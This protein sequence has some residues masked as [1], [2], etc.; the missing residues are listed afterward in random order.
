MASEPLS[1]TAEF[2]DRFAGLAL[3]CVDREYPN[4]I[5][6]LVQSDAESSPRQLSAPTYLY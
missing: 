4:H 6:H 3:D 5:L 2:A 1:L